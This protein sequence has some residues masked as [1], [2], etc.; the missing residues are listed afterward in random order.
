MALFQMHPSKAPGPDDISSFFYKKY[1]HIVGLS[2]SNAVL[3]VLN[4]GKILQKINL[5]HISLIP[6]KKNPECMSDFR[7]ISLC[8]MIYKIISK[9]FANRLKLVLPCIIL[10]SQSAF[11]PGRLITDNVSVAFELIHKLK[12]KRTGK[13]GEMAIKLDMS[14]AYDLVEWIYLESIMRRMGFAE[15]WISLIMECIRT[16]QYSVL[17]DGVPKG[18]IIPSQGIQQGDPLSAYMFLLCAEGLSVLFHKAGFLGNLKGIQ[19]CPRG[20]WVSHLFFADDSLL[21]GQATLSECLKIMDILGC[22]ER[23]SGQKSRG[24]KRQS[25]SAIT[26]LIIANNLFKISRVHMRC[27]TL[28]NT[29]ASRR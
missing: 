27:I 25:S 8:N 9:V 23:C 5:A 1:W 16:V 19:S 26:P 15:R 3:S 28:I 12:A 20:P 6:K 22:Y 2:V 7:P 11:V 14:K 17:I 4:S 10:E 13:K 29:W 21:F 18:F 24:T